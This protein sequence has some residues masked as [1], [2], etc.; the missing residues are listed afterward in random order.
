VIA[1]AGVNHNGDVALAR[2][3]VD[4]AADCGADAV[5][6]QTF[7]PS[8]LA[9]TAAPKAEYQMREDAATS[10]RE[11][12]ERLALPPQAHRELKALA[13]SRGIVF[14]SSP[15]DEGSADFL[16][17]LDVPAFKIP[18]GEVTNHPLLAHVARKGRPVLMSTGMCDLVDVAEAVDVIRGAGD[19]PLALFHCVSNYPADP[20]E[21]NLEAMRTLGQAFG[22]SVGWSDHTPGIAIATA[23]V[24]MGAELIEKHVTLDKTMPGPDH[25]ASLDPAEFA[26]LVRTVREVERARGDGRK[27]PKPDE[28]AIAA[29]ARKSLHWRDSLDGGA[30]VEVDHLVALRPGTGVPPS[31]MAQVVGRR[32]RQRV[33]AGSMVREEQMEARP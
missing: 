32:L 28:R 5:K 11:M 8:R 3:L 4:T 31:K 27:V 24:A 17:S 26:E 33:E 20:G 18:S 16:E 10:Q 25:R 7:D 29:V 22:L 21:A 12:L 1:E 19:P 6:F 30:T 9:S 23:A 13:E 14:L 2:R 15:F